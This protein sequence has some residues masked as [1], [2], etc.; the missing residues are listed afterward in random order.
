MGGFP[1]GVNFVHNILLI[2]TRA[3]PKSWRSGITV[4]VPRIPDKCHLLHCPYHAPPL[5]RRDCAECLMRGTVAIT[6]WTDARISWP[7]C[8]RLEGKCHPS[9]LL[10]DQ[11]ARAI[12]T[13]SA[14][15]VRYC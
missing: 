7:R 9:L 4:A 3:P 2:G 12:R 14:T 15:A 1:E 8:R 13:E 11:L 6:G 5:R 10:D